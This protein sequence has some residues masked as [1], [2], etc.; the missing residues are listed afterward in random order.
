M[1]LFANTCCSNTITLLIFEEQTSHIMHWAQGI[2]HRSVQ[3]CKNTNGEQQA[4]ASPWPF[5]SGGGSRERGSVPSAPSSLLR[6]GDWALRQLLL[7]LFAVAAG[8]RQRELRPSVPRR[9]GAAAVRPLPSGSPA[10]SA[11]V[12]SG[13]AAALLRRSLPKDQGHAE[14]RRH[15]P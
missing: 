13:R 12:A 10:A 1:I 5:C 7:A 11:V 6:R 15:R 9:R 8:A 2:E 4:A 14:W 3:K